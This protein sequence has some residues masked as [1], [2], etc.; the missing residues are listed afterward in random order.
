[1]GAVDCDKMND[2]E[3]LHEFVERFIDYDGKRDK[4]V[5]YLQALLSEAGVDYE[6]H[7]VWNELHTEQDEAFCRCREIVRVVKNDPDAMWC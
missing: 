1:M 2:T 5:G 3:L 7:G 6:G 4:L